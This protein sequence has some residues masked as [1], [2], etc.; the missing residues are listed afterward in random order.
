[1]YLFLYFGVSRGL[2]SCELIEF[3]FWTSLFI[4]FALLTS[5]F[6]DMLPELFWITCSNASMV[7]LI[8][9]IVKLFFRI[10]IL[11]CSLS[12]YVSIFCKEIHMVLI[13]SEDVS[14]PATRVIGFTYLSRLRY[15]SK[16]GST[17]SWWFEACCNAKRL[18]SS[19]SFFF[20]SC[21]NST[22]TV[23]PFWSYRT[24]V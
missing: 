15:S 7:S 12:S 13:F 6:G 22:A 23:C 5:F 24:R 8:L 3:F 9:S 2:S 14:C 21:V 17:T 1:M 20:S 4:D 11:F 19:S 18:W 10:I 16:S